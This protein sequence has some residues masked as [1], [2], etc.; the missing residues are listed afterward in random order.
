MR[1]QVFEL[2]LDDGVLNILSVD[3]V[4]VVLAVLLV[5]ERVNNL[6]VDSEVILQL[7]ILLSQVSHLHVKLLYLEFE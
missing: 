4:R 2:V 6:F 7:F 5:D 1:G 3:F